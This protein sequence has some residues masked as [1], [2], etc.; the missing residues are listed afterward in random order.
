MIVLSRTELLIIEKESLPVVPCG[1]F[2]KFSETSEPFE[3]VFFSEKLNFS[4]LVRLQSKLRF[5]FS[6][7]RSFTYSHTTSDLSHGNSRISLD[8]LLYMALR[9]LEVFKVHFRPPPGR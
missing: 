1:P 2:Q 9:F 4:Q 3:F 8:S 7:H 5:C 6:P